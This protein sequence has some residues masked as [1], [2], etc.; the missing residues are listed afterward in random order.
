MRYSYC[1]DFA[2]LPHSVW[3]TFLPVMVLF[4]CL[5]ESS[6]QIVEIVSQ[7]SI[8]DGTRKCLSPLNVNNLFY[9]SGGEQNGLNLSV[10]RWVVE[11]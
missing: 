1:R 7:T 4:R 11:Q 8:W 6:I 3:C 9:L 5:A 10:E 2:Q